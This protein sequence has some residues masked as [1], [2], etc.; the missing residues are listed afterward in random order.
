ML[1]FPRWRR[2]RVRAWQPSE[3]T[4]LLLLSVL[5]GLSTG[6]GIVVFRAGIGFFHEWAVLRLGNTL[7]GDALAAVG[8]P[9]AFSI[10]PVLTLAGFVVGWLMLR[11]VGTEK[12]HGVAGIMEAVALSGGR[13][14]YQKMPPKMLAS[15]LSIGAGAS[16]GPEDPSVQIGSNIG[17]FFG[18]RLRLSEERVRLMVSAGAASAIAAAFN[19]PI[20]GVFFA[21]E[22]ILGEFTTRSFGVVVLSAVISAGFARVFYGTNPIFDGLESFVLGSPLQLVFY[23]ILGL[24]LAFFA[25]F[26]IRYHAWQSEKLHHI[27]LYRP[28]KTAL[29]GALVGAVGVFFPPILGAGEVF[30]HDVLTGHIALELGVFFFLA[31]LK[32][33]MTTVSQGGGFVGGVFAPTLFMGIM[34]GYGYGLATTAFLPVDVVG[35]PQAFAIAGMAG[36]LA[37]IVRAPITA[38]MLVFEITRDYALILPIMLTTVICTTVAEQLG[39]AGIYMLSLLKQGVHLQQGRDI[40]LM[41]SLT[42][43]EAMVTPPP[44]IHGSASLTR[45]RDTFREQHTRALCVVNDAQ[46]LCGIVTLSDLQ[47][48]FEKHLDNPDQNALNM[49]TVSDICQRDVVTLYPDDGLWTAIQLMGARD[50]GR[51]PVLARGTRHVVGIVRRQDI[52]HAY[53]VAMARKARDQHVAERVRLQTLTGAHVLSFHVRKGSAQDG[54]TIASIAWPPEAAVVSIERKGRL[55]VPHGHTV[56]QDNDVVTVIADPQSELLLKQ[57]FA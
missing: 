56:L 45:L 46:E 32:L 11:F 42:V 54:R 27:T 24:G 36:L 51:I 9:R 21:L 7:I 35:Q 20:A 16:V 12:Y 3:N 38:I 25:V 17:A 15:M 6:L 28:F 43:A 41:Q 37:G 19:A 14:R 31:V 47:R 22:V 29:V 18:Q 23:A 34:L 8:I 52:M 40:D 10:I 30:M 33:V 49:L 57:M 4:A 48:T 39:T 55:I 5:V 26:A 13:L 2:V 50:I 1:N 44:L 53:N